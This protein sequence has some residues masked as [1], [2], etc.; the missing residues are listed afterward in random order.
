[1]DRKIILYISESVDGYIA[2]KN[3]G[4][5]WIKGQ[6]ESYESDYGYYDFLK[7]IDT[8]I[9]GENTYYQ[10]RKDL[11]PDTW[12]YEGMKTYVFSKK[13]EPE[14]LVTPKDVEFVQEDLIQFMKKLKTMD[15]KGIWICG[16]AS[17]V[18]QLI[19]ANLIDEYQIETVPVLLGEGVRLF[20]TGIPNQKLELTDI[21]EENGLLLTKYQL[22]G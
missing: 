17:I 11:S 21:R 18:N 16:G 6:D 14:G 1:M 19:R 10:I 5:D 15:G 22:R 13:G 8:V 7:E 20:E 12:V 2:D 4:V 3:G 9:L